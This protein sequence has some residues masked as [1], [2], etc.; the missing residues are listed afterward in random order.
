MTLHLADNLLLPS[1]EAVSQKYAFIG[2]F[3]NMLGSLRSLGIVAYPRGNHASL[4]E[5]FEAVG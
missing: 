5:L 3:N 1:G 2:H 4:S